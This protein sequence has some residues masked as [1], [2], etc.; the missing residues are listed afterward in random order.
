MADNTHTVH[1]EELGPDGF[2]VRDAV[3]TSDVIRIRFAD[4]DGLR[5][6]A[7]LLVA[8]SVL[9]KYTIS[10]P[11]ALLLRASGAASQGLALFFV[12]SGFAL[13]FPAMAVLRQDGRTYVDVGR[14]AIRRFLRIYPA[15][16]VAL[17]LTV[18]F[19]SVEGRLNPAG[20]RD[21]NP[22]SIA[23]NMFFVG[24]GF[25][26]DG[27]SAVALFVRCYI[28]FPALVWLWTRRPA[29]FAGLAAV[30]ALLD[31][32][33]PAH[34]WSVAAFL[35]FMLGIVAADLRAQVHRFERFAP[36]VFAVAAVVAIFA[37]PLL[38]AAPGFT[39]APAALVVDPFWSIAA[40]GLIVSVAAYRPLERIFSFW[41]LR[42]VGASS[43]AVSLALVPVAGLLVATVAKY[44]PGPLLPLSFIPISFFIGFVF[45]QFV[46]RWFNDG[47]FRRNSAVSY[48][49]PI[50]EALSKVRA[51]RVFLGGPPAEE[52]DEDDLP[53]IHQ[54]EFVPSFYAP[55]P[56]ASAA[57]LAIVSRR[58]GS[59][60]ELQNAILETKARLQE[61]SA[62]IFAEDEAM[63]NPQPAPV[64]AKP[65]FY[66]KPAKQS[67]AGDDPANLEP[68]TGGAVSGP[69]S[70]AAQGGVQP[71]AAVAA[72]VPGP[73][74]K[75][76]ISAKPAAPPPAPETIAASDGEPDAAPPKAPPEAPNEAPKAEKGPAIRIRITNSSDGVLKNG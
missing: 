55:P 15:Y 9:V 74:L 32:F 40:F 6:L 62:A 44:L 23:A 20:L 66:R 27:F 26:N 41:A 34:A 63:R 36:I 42:I 22:G 1:Q 13:A 49:A 57:D 43:F 8:F 5:A 24:N 28:F 75:H 29:I 25:G 38:A 76:T 56:R 30:L 12:I 31:I 67:V 59:P 35:P 19:A 11:S 73:T 54:E 33:T 68:L 69:P 2:V 46:D 37:A 71:A 21:V 47:D 72:P 48:A 45:W 58:T 60:E 10:A 70:D 14:Y 50:D 53:E 52:S 64:F 39:A 16:I 51:D 4:I 7:I 61:R 3:P 65:G 18:I 17:V